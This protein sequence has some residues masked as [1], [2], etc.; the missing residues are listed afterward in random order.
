MNKRILSI[1]T[2]LTLSAAGLSIAG[3]SVAGLGVASASTVTY[4]VGVSSGGA[5]SSALYTDTSAQTIRLPLASVGGTVPGDLSLSASTLPSGVTMT[6][7]SAAQDG[8][9][10]VLAV[11]I[12]RDHTTVAVD[13]LAN[14]ALISG[15]ATLT[16]FQVPV[17]SAAVNAPFRLPAAS[18]DSY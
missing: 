2:A 1:L 10:L 16:V 11:N 14:V 9:S 12:V 4:D 6:L 5:A 17:Q 3:L 8:D 13:S 18:N 7:L 15:N